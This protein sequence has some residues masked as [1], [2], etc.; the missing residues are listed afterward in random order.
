M[1]GMGTAVEGRVQAQQGPG[2]QI[3]P[4]MPEGV[5]RTEHRVGKHAERAPRKA[6][7]VHSVPV[8]QT[9]TGGWGEDPKADGRSIVKELGKKVP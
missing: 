4:G 8:P 5:M 6:A 2:R 7:I 3:P 1:R 9:D